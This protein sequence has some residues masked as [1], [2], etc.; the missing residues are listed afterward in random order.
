M[1]ARTRWITFDCFG[2]L[3]DWQAGFAAALRPIVGDRT[4]DVLRAYHVHE[5]T[6]EREQ[7][8]RAYKDVL[9]TAL[10]RAADDCGVPLS[11]T[12]ARALPDAWP[13][14]RPFGDVEAMLAELRLR[15][16]RL[17]VLT[18]C[19]EDLFQVTHRLFSEPFDFVLTA[20]RIRG[21]KPAQWHFRG[22]QRLMRVARQDWVHVANSWYHDISPTQMLGIQHVWLDRDRTGETCVAASHVYSTGDVV[23]AVERLL[24]GEPCTDAPVCC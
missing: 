8:H 12:A 9:V 24:A 6:V 23:D 3:V 21:Y 17:A 10:M 14:I 7:P 4:R 13:S 11:R 22:F 15:G 16:C 19:D 5:R 1:S 18:N 20:E 2:T